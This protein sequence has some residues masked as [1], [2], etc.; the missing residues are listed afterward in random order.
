MNSENI[1]NIKKIPIVAYLTSNGYEPVRTSGSRVFFHSP[2]RSDS[3]PSFVVNLDSN[4][5]YDFGESEKPDDIIKLVQRLHGLSFVDACS[6][7]SASPNIGQT[8]PFSFSGQTPEANPE[9]SITTV[10]GLKH[11]S[12]IQYAV[13]RGIP[14]GLA[15]H[16]LKEIHYTFK[17]RTYFSLGF[18]NDCGGYVLRN[19]VIKRNIGPNGVSTLPIVGS[20]AINVFEG[21]FDFLSAIVLYG[22]PTQSTVVLN[23][24]SNLTKALPVLSQYPK[25]SVFLD[26]DITGR[27]A[28]ET[29]RAK[30]FQVIDRSKTYE[31][32]NDLN[33]FLMETRKF[34]LTKP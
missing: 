26:N 4:T 24:T 25:L 16:Y 13:S 27:R 19:G 5:F 1:Q 3:T 15:M 32:Y 20:T 14:Y 31:G 30:G 6:R 7:L 17:G 11:L 18:A 12:L 23:S 10:K 33:E 22:Y 34:E 28:V 8:V 21:F 9:T 2:F 29:L